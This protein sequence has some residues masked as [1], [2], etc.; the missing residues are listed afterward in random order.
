MPAYVLSGGELWIGNGE[1][2]R[3]HV[4]VE[5]GVIQK[6]VAGDYGG[7]LERVNVSGLSI[8]PGMI[9]LMVG[10]GF[11]FSIL[12]DDA[13]EITRRY[14]RHGVTQCQFFFGTRP[15]EVMERIVENVRRERRCPASDATELLGLYM[16]GPFQHPDRTGGSQ[17]AYALPPTP[18]LTKRVL[19]RWG[20]VVSMTNISPGVEGDVLAIEHFVR[21]GVIVSMAHSAAPAERVMSCIQAGTTVLG[22]CWDNNSGLIGDSGVQQPTLEHVALLDERVRSIHLVCDGIHAHPI[23]VRLILRCRG[24]DAVTLVTD[25]NQ[26][27]GAPDGAFTNDDGMPRYKRGDVCRTEAGLLCGSALLLPEMFR[28]FV[29]YTGLAPWQ[30]IRAVTLNPARSFGIAERTGLLAPGREANMVAWNQQLQVTRVWKKGVPV[31]ALEQT[32]SA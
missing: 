7:S 10:G 1:A 19:D 14:L 30:A 5:D 16:E 6:V 25:T 26:G 17:R 29:Q 15:W 27:S 22:H 2:L 20:D 4:V 28:R 24:L 31:P 8:S 9:D 12:R 23:M 13:S 3:G 32:C 21:A 11:G 18:E